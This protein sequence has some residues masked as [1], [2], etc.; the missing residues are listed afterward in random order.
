MKTLIVEKP[1]GKFEQFTHNLSSTVKILTVN[2]GE[3]FSLQSHK[4]RT[5]F[6]RVIS[7]SGE[8]E[9]GEVKSKIIEGDETIISP[10]TKHRIFAGENGIK[11]LEIS[12]GDFDEEDIIRYHDKYGRT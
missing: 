7:G 12:T 2:S 4:N 6:W 10:G 9:I 8:M 11:V 3:A 1:W 5:E